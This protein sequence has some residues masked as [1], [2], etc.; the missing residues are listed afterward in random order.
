MESKIYMID[1]DNVN[2]QYL[3]LGN[4]YLLPPA[5]EKKQKSIMGK[6]AE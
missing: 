5:P 3:V 4:T 6:E 2:F 1:L